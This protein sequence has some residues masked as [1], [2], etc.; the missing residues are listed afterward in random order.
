MAALEDTLSGKIKA[1]RTPD[2]RPSEAI[3]DPGD[4]A[5]LV[6]AHPRI[7]D[8]PPDDVQRALAR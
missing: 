6:E 3:K 1:W 8:S 7:A 2:R 5:R 4:I